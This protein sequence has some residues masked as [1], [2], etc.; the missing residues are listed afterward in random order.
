MPVWAQ[1]LASLVDFLGDQARSGRYFLFRF[2]VY[3][4]CSCSSLIFP[5]P[6]CQIR[7]I[8][9]VARQLSPAANSNSAVLVIRRPRVAPCFTMP[10]ST[11]SSW[12]S[13]ERYCRCNSTLHQR[14]QHNRMRHA[15]SATNP[16]IKKSFVHSGLSCRNF[17][18]NT[19]AP[20]KN[21][22]QIVDVSV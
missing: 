4:P 22:E 10:N 18:L 13:T 9:N 5:Y 19:S 8:A 7:T 1:A 3:R 15:V 14:T 6:I 2:L 12:R 20:H 11:L 16:N 17:S 21:A